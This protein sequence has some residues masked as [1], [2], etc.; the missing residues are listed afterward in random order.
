[1]DAVTEKMIWRVFLYT[2]APHNQRCEES[3]LI[4]YGCTVLSLT[5]KVLSRFVLYTFLGQRS[6]GLFTSLDNNEPS[7]KEQCPPFLSQSFLHRRSPKEA[8]EK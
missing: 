5:Q 8:R 3:G 2:A 1:M 4:L 7:R 6:K